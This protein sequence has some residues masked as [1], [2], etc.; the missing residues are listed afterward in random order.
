MFCDFGD[1]EFRRGS[2]AGDVD[3]SRVEMVT[4]AGGVRDSDPRA[5][6]PSEE[7]RAV[8][9]TLRNS[10]ADHRAGKI[11]KSNGLEKQGFHATAASL[12][13]LN[14]PLCTLGKENKTH[15][16]GHPSSLKICFQIPRL[17][18]QIFPSVSF[19][20]F[21]ANAQPEF[22]DHLLYNPPPKQQ[23]DV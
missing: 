1:L 11:K 22:L 20:D 3:G 2:G 13:L 7:E 19:L 14:S 15:Q 16:S 9:W 21:V 12:P 4:R 6:I 5:I 17:S 18:F 8:S 10:G 23:P